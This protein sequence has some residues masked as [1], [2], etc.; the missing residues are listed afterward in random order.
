[1][2][3]KIQQEADS[4]ISNNHSFKSE[5]NMNESKLQSTGFPIEW[6]VDPPERAKCTLCFQILNE[7]RNCRNGHLF[8][9][10]CIKMTTSND[11]Q[12]TCPTC[13]TSMKE[14]D[15]G[16]C[17]YVKEVNMELNAHCSCFFK[18][19]RHQEQS[20]NCGWNGMFKDRATRTCAYQMVKCS[21]EGCNVS[22]QRRL[23][24]IH[25]G[26]ECELRQEACPFCKSRMRFAMIGDHKKQCVDRPVKCSG[27][28]VILPFC[29]LNAHHE[30]CSCNCPLFTIGKCA[31]DCTGQV[32]PP[33]LEAHLRADAALVAEL[34]ETVH[35]LQVQLMAERRENV[36]RKVKRKA[37]GPAVEGQQDPT[38]EASFSTFH[39][40]AT[41]FV[42]GLAY[43][44]FVIA[45]INM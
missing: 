33:L 30:T 40:G 15:L 19:D 32:K 11:N 22:V 43:E 28:S 9:F 1:M 8:C 31:A 37:D 20:D 45:S 7:P 34:A 24:K 12:M 25:K 6:F 17:L 29:Q 18:T 27:C 42:A 39:G 5:I 23:L 14:Q 21:N 10:E 4:R 38:E 13:K 36:A 35:A 16:L 2:K 3:Q 41:L 44:V 26:S